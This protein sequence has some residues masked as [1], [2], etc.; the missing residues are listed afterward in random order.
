MFLT[1][2]NS[3]LDSRK[4][5]LPLITCLIKEVLK[6]KVERR[7]HLFIC[8]LDF[9]RA[10]DTVSHTALL[11]LMKGARI[12]AKVRAYE[13]T[14]YE[15]SVLWV[16]AGRTRQELGVLQGDPLSPL[17]FKLSLPIPVIAG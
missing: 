13:K 10:F 2:M 11:N 17:L 16:G 14:L 8:F 4:T 3:N 15:N 9:R 7:K 1:I 12:P 5:C 6:R